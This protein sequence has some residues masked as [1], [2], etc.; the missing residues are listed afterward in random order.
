MVKDLPETPYA[1][2]DSIRDDRTPFRL[3]LCAA[4][5]IEWGVAGWL[6]RWLYRAADRLDQAR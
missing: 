4:K 6:S 3:R 2:F 5:L 1:G